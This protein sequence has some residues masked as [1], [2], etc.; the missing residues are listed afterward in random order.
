MKTLLLT[1]E[2]KRLFSFLAL[3]FYSTSLCQA[4]PSDPTVVAGEVQFERVNDTTM[5]I[6]ASS[7]SILEYASFNIG[8]GET[9]NFFL[10]D[11]DAFSLNRILGGSASDIMGNLFSNG[12][13][14]LINQFGFN[15]GASA[16][17]DTHGLIASALNMSNENFLN[18]NFTF[19]NDGNSPFSQI[20]NNGLIQT[21]NGFTVLIAPSIENNGAIT[22]PLGTVALASGDV[23]TVG[24]NQ[25]NSISIAVEEPVSGQVLDSEGNEVADQIK[26]TGTLEAEGGK[27]VLN[28]KGANE[29]FNQTI[30]LQGHVR[31]DR[32]EVGRDGVIEITSSGRN[33][34]GGEISAS[35]DIT[36]ATP[37]SA[38]FTQAENS[39]VEA[40]GD[41]TISNGVL[42][43][44]NNAHYTIGGDW[45]NYGTFDP[46]TS[47]VEFNDASQDSVIYGSND[48][49]DFS[50]LTASKVIRFEAGETQN[51][52]GSITTRG[53]Y[54]QHVRLISTEE[55]SHWM[56][57]PG[58][59]YDFSYSW[60]E[61]SVN[62]SPE[63]IIMTESTNRGN[64]VRWDPVATWTG[65]G[66]NALWS[67]PG[68]WSGIGGSTPGAGD[69]VT[70]DG[71]TPITG[72]N[73]STVDAGF[74][75]TIGSLITVAAYT[76]TITL[77]R[78]L[79]VTNAS[80]R[81]GDI[82]LNT[83]AVL[84]IS[85][86]TL[87]V[88]GN[89][90]NPANKITATGSTIDFARATTIQTFTYGTTDYNNITHSGAGTFII[91]GGD[92]AISV[93]NLTNSVGTTVLGS[94][95]LIMSGTFSN[96]AIFSMVGNN[97]LVNVTPDLDSGTIMYTGDGDSAVDSYNVGGLF[98]G[99]YYGLQVA[100]TD[101]GDTANFDAN[102]SVAG[103]LTV[104]G[105]T[106]AM[107]NGFT[108]TVTGLTTV[109]GG[110]YN[111]T[112]GG[113]QTFNGG[114]TISGGT[115]SA[116]SGTV[117]VNGDLTLSS[118]TLNAPSGNLEI[119]GNFAVSGSPTFNSNSGT[120]IF[121]SATADQTFTTNGISLNNLTLNN[122]FASGDLIISGALDVNGSLILTDGNLD[123][124]TNDPN[125]N[126]AG[127]M[128]VSANGTLN[129]NSGYTGTWTFD[130]TGT[131]TLTDN[132]AA[133]TN[134]GSITVDGS[135][136][137]VLQLAGSSPGV[138]IATL[139]V[140]ADDTFSL[141]SESITITTLIN[142]GTFRLQGGETVTLSTQDVDSGTWEYT[143]DGD[144]A[145][146]SYTIKDFG[147]TDYFNFRITSTDSGD[148]YSSSAAKSIAD[149]LNITAGTYNANGQATTVTGLTTVS[150]GTYQ[151][152]TA[153]QT[154][155]SGLTVSG[156]TF[157]GS[158]GAVD[159]NGDM[160]LSSGAFTAP[161]GNTFVSGNWAQTGGTFTHNSGT[162]NFDRAGGTQTLNSGGSSFN[163]LTHSGTST[164]QAITN[165]LA[166]ANNLTNSAGTFDMNGLTMTQSA[167]NTTISGGIYTGLTNTQ[168]LNN[169][170]VTGGTFTGSTGAVDVNGNVSITDGT[171]TAPSGNFTV[172]GNWTRSGTGVFDPGTNTVDF[173]RG[174]GSQLLNSGGTSFYNVLHSGAGTLSLLTNNLTVG[175]T[176]TQSAG[177]YNAVTRTTTVTGLATLSG[178]TYNASTATQ[179]FNGGLTISGGTYTGSSGALDING[180]L[181][182]SS[183]TLT[184]PSSTLN[185][186]GN[187]AQSG[188][189]FTH[190][191]GTVIFDGAG[192]ISGN[193]VFN[194]LSVQA[195]RQITGGTG[196]TVQNANTFTVGN[197]VTLTST[198][199]TQWNLNINNAGG[200]DTGFSFGTNDTF[201][202]ANN[203]S[204]NTINA[205][206]VTDGGNN[207]RFTFV[208]ATQNNSS[209]V[210]SSGA[211]DSGINS[212]LGSSTSGFSS[213]SSSSPASSSSSESSSSGSS[214]SESSSSPESES[215]DSDD[216]S[217]GSNN[218]SGDNATEGSEENSENNSGDGSEGPNELGD[219]DGP[220]DSNAFPSV[221]YHMNQP[222]RFQALTSCKQGLVVVVSNL[223][224]EVVANLKAGQSKMVLGASPKGQRHA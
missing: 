84:D 94:N 88:Y 61:D 68:N 103:P 116:G 14:I 148:S 176:F 149:A 90:F 70:F 144:A 101:A 195:N 87:T 172:N 200:S 15:F 209:S 44:A 62:L 45:A 79:T 55:G 49:Y 181:T 174:S 151:A 53:A 145:A 204:T 203:T 198:N 118:G 3:F 183:G 138:T 20:V 142:N 104:S 193:P 187:W 120:V 13:L 224:G 91:G 170:L 30:N 34:L 135:S 197:N 1:P 212:A 146:D 77:A 36:L 25:D 41:F 166:V 56:I 167:G 96:S 184:A 6:T 43:E 153:T 71:L 82:N 211:V 111:T 156:G 18:G 27:I 5:N 158:S 125:V 2:F 137:K 4:L 102:L 29:L 12:N 123:V 112:I 201:A 173:D 217:E 190:N 199:T 23:V 131:D 132:T 16:N 218:E 99:Q 136:S 17:V 95:T 7:N 147:A 121:N 175:G 127:D 35:G 51:I 139:T 179:T 114:L 208:A 140:G 150:G 57:N 22:A 159:I 186:S 213:S 47:S 124:A 83:N 21:D 40:G 155:N 92:G 74:A 105:G 65:G 75:G 54:G 168:T 126:I 189:T 194:I 81:T 165:N 106:L 89:L 113:T 78:S 164:L 154:F 37:D 10:P 161:S 46:G 192:T 222:G 117:D 42:L 63:E 19:T 188:G 191:S 115:F 85:N 66:G 100:M 50:V 214:S 130:G 215:S 221:D 64:S 143:G 205:L 160:T 52:L 76:N 182:F 93:A 72:N 216:S 220:K 185:V 67:N 207:T 210:V 223:T 134:L 110:V 109:S 141:N 69:D 8:I 180:D 48:F 169:L 177:T 133:G 206:T 219:S 97:T 122:T 108:N 32:A 38:E 86:Q 73:A 11:A 128:T 196:I 163:H 98:G 33:T 157:T 162:V 107:G 171:L 202:Y 60:V 24:I 178:G 129:A 28:A 152:S 80:G 31:A 59:N 119:S 9:V 26:N 58:S 39:T